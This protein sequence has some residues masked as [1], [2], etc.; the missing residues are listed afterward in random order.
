M[1]GKP[2]PDR[3]RRFKLVALAT[4]LLVIVAALAVGGWALLRPRPARVAVAASFSR[5]SAASMPATL[6]E[7]PTS[8]P[9][10]EPTQAPSS[11]AAA[12][13]IR[14]PTAPA[15]PPAA[16]PPPPPAPPPGPP[17]I[18]INVP[19]YHQQYNLS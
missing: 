12:P 9:T 4:G 11:R 3:R 7:T 10:P 6:T 16:L 5:P 18:T 14:T 17:P 8:T 15:H 1:E 19:W 2:T 13:P